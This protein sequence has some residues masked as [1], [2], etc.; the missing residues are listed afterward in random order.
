VGTSPTGSSPRSHTPASEWRSDDDDAA[1][2]DDGTEPVTTVDGGCTT[3]RGGATPL[4][5]V[6]ALG[7]VARCR[8]RRS[9]GCW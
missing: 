1:I 3:S 9:S 4:L 7:F 8:R 6:L 2:A 5:I